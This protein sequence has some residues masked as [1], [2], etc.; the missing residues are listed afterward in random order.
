MTRSSVDKTTSYESQEGFTEVPPTPTK[1]SN[2]PTQQ[3]SVELDQNQPQPNQQMTSSKTE[4]LGGRPKTRESV[5]QKTS[6]LRKIPPKKV[7]V[8]PTQPAHSPT[9]LGEN[10][11]TLPPKI[12]SAELISSTDTQDW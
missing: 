2:H 11:T 9:N 3:S 7:P 12:K 8:P 1:L 10:T 6:Q 4:N 5:K